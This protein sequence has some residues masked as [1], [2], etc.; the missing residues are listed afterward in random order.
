MYHSHLFREK[1]KFEKPTSV[2]NSDFVWA[3]I[4][5]ITFATRESINTPRPAEGNI[6]RNSTFLQFLSMQELESKKVP[7][8][9]RRTTDKTI[10]NRKLIILLIFYPQQI[11]NKAQDDLKSKETETNKNKESK[12]DLFRLSDDYIYMSAR[13]SKKPQKLQQDRTFPLNPGHKLQRDNLH[14]R[15]AIP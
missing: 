5:Y 12:H 8:N 9:R 3:Y 10:R 13:L 4:T 1:G 14:N 15:I 2:E 7:F 11:E 6:H